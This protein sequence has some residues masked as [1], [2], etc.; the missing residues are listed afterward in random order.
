MLLL[1]RLGIEEGSKNG[2][3]S[4]KGIDRLDRRVENYY[5]GDDDRN[6]L[7][8]VSNAKRQGRDFIQGHV[9]ELIVQ[10]IKNALGRYPPDEMGANLGER[11]F[12][13]S[14]PHCGSLNSNSEGREYHERQHR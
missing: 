6:S 5:R 11:I 8:G 2:D 12:P 7:H 9:R 10:M 13:S 14:S 3:G 4:S 1:L